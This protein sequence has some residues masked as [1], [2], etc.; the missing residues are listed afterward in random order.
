MTPSLL[1]KDLATINLFKRRTVL[2]WLVLALSMLGLIVRLVYLQVIASP[3]LLEKARRQQMFTMRPFIPRRT[4]TDRKGAVLALDRPVYT[5]FAHPHLYKKKP[6][7]IA[8]K[9]APILRRPADKLLSVLTRDITSIQ[10]EYWL[11]EEKADLIF[12]LGLDGLDLVQQ[13]HRLYP[14]QDLAAELLGY[15]NVDHRGQAGIELSQ[16]KLLERTDQAPLVAQDGNGKFIPNHIPA[17]MLQSDRTSLQ[18]TIDSRIQRN[19][20]QILKQQ[21]VKFGAKRGSVIVMDVRDG[22]LL[23]LVTEPTY[24]P[25]RYYESDVK[26]FKNWAVSDLFEPGSTFKPINVAIALEAGAIQPD[27]VFNDE[28]ALTI[29]GWPV[30][31]FDY[32]QVGAVGSLSISQI[33]ERSS[34]VGMVHIIQRMKPSVYYGWLERIGLGDMS[35]IDLPAET[36]STLKPQEQFIEYVIEPATASFGQGFSLTPIQMVQLQG[37]LASGGKLLTPHVVKGLINDEGEEYYQPKLP[38][39]RQVISH[40]TAQRVVEMMT[41]VVEKGTGLPARIPGYRIAGKTGTAQKASTTGGGYINAKITSFVGI[42]PSKEPRYVVLAVIDEPVGADA[43][44][45][46][47]AA[48]IVKTVI[49]DI[50]VS[51]GIPPSHPEEVISKIPILPEPSASPSPQD[52]KASPNTSPSAAPTPSRDRSNSPS[53]SSTPPSDRT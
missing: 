48:P 34:N 46:T 50:I 53:P 22:G 27:T 8:D 12:S 36:S 40:A 14:Q 21:M 43:F 24:D 1:P 32:D 25:N 2:I 23:S 28:G 5:L 10:V 41:N 4:I 44:G 7:E 38:T 45:S 35:G 42:F 49:E 31:N 9:L 37:I 11:S 17:G 39:P 6:E 13:R 52:V 33:L 26:L 51:E 16:E 18:M 30:A 20:R 3:D 15:V 47:V 19:A 29:G